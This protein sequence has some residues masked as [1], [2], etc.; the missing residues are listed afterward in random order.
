[1]RSGTDRGREEISPQIKDVKGREG[2]SK[3]PS[4]K[5]TVSRL[6]KKKKKSTPMLLDWGGYMR[7][8]E[9]ELITRLSLG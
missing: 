4:A 1:M 5:V 7:R 8:G 6:R 3:C 2:L 9:K